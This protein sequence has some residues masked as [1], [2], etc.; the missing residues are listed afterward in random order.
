M[1]CDPPFLLGKLNVG[2][3][4]FITLELVEMLIISILLGLKNIYIISTENNLV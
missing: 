3:L 2:F 1:I 4:F